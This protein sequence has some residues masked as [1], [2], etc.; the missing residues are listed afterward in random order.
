MVKDKNNV[1][2]VG[3]PEENYGFG[4]GKAP[5][6]SKPNM[7]GSL[8]NVQQTNQDIEAQPSPTGFEGQDFNDQD[9]YNE[10]DNEA[11]DKNELYRIFKEDEGKE[12]CKGISKN[13]VG[14]FGFIKNR[15]TKRPKNRFTRN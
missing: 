7:G 14:F 3:A 10:Y 15:M 11:K 8:V 13:I 2:R 6:E 1:E 12:Y 5:K 9:D 4:M